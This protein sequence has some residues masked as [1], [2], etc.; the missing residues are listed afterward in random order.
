MLKLDKSNVGF[1]GGMNGGPGGSFY[2][3]EALV[4]YVP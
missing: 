2:N 3:A 1:G 4:F